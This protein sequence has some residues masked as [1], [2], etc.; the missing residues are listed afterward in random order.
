MLPTSP[1][2]AARSTCSSWTTPFAMAA[3]RVS[4][5]VTL[6][7]MSSAMTG[8][9][10]AGATAKAQGARRARRVLEPGLART[11][12]SDPVVDRSRSLGPR[13]GGSRS[14]TEPRLELAQQARRLVERQAHHPRVAAEDLGDER[15]P[16][17][18]GGVAPGPV[19]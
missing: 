19:E 14:L 6:I 8:G 9:A 1:R 16:A 17:G 11:P 3:T 13:V 2:L 10:W 5:G 4:C 12:G 15:G 18:L 7:R